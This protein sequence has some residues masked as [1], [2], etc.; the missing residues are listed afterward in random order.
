M[1]T[2]RRKIARSAVR[3]VKRRA[4]KSVK[5]KLRP[6]RSRKNAVH[7]SY[8]VM[9]G[10]RLFRGNANLMYPTNYPEKTRKYEIKFLQLK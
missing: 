1:A 9:R 3:R 6:L 8:R 5:R 2:R 7:K 4:S 10:G